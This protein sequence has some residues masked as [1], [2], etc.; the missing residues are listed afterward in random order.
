MAVHVEVDEHGFGGRNVQ[1]VAAGAKVGAL[2]EQE[3]MAQVVDLI[4]RPLFDE[5]LAEHFGERFVASLARELNL[6]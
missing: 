3:G 5:I 6:V 1:V 2:K 4:L